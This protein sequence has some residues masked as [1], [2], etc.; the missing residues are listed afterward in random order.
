M[1]REEDLIR[2]TTHAIAST[3]REVPPLRLEEAPDELRYPARAPRR[4]RGRPRGWWSWGAPLTAA[5][6]VVVLAIALVIVKD[7]PNGSEVPA[8]PAT[9]TGP[10]GVPR[11][12]VALTLSRSTRS[13]IVVVGDSLTGKT[14]ATFTPPAGRIFGNVTAAADDRTFVVSTAAPAGK[15]TT[16]RWYEIRL[17]PGSA[18]PARMTP[19]PITPQ[20]LV[21]LSPSLPLT[22]GM[23]A[24]AF[25]TALSSS[26]KQ[27]AVAEA[28]ATGMAV[29]VFSV[30][31]GRLL[32]DWAENNATTRMETVVGGT[33]ATVPV[34]TPS[35]TW[36][37]ND[38]AVAFAT[39]YDTSNTVLG[40]IRRLDVSGPASGNLM[41]DSTVIWSGTVPW[42]Q[43]RGCFQVDDWPPLISADG[44]SISCLTW[45][46][47]ANTPG[48]VDFDTYPLVTGGQPTLN[49]RATILPENKTG[50]LNA[51][52]LWVSPSADTLIVTW[53]GPGLKPA[54]GSHFGVISHGKFTPLPLQANR[55][56]LLSMD[57]TF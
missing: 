40:T 56:A 46:M 28:N 50:G 54:T 22:Q 44:N 21:I 37:D 8:N 55:A 7:M 20:T 9:S 41:A 31:T 29:K 4:G 38:R 34:G 36:I 6:V 3:V 2:S 23:A 48:H 18:N 24:E 39:S 14:L 16:N 25:P 12:Y 26:G 57:I 5:A 10:G 1:S 17:A 13:S 42:N 47:P 32:H 30:A 27:L 49:Y 53:G 15:S 43:S 35:L 33:M 52:V 51:S 11:Y 19:L 45:D